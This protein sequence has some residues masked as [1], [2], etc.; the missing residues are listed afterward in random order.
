MPG[1]LLFIDMGDLIALAIVGV[2]IGITVL[3]VMARE[4]FRIW[5]LKRKFQA[6]Q[7]LIDPGS[8]IWPGPQIRGSFRGRELDG[9]RRN[10]LIGFTLRSGTYGKT[11][12]EFRCVSALHFTAF[13]LPL[14][15]AM[16]E[17]L[18]LGSPRVATG[19]LKVDKDFG[20][21][22]PDPD[23]LRSW[24]ENADNRTALLAF[25]S[26][27]PASRQQRFRVRVEGKLQLNM[28]EYQFF[29]MSPDRIRQLLE[30]LE[31]MAGK[32]EQVGG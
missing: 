7:A 15:P 28:P 23:R 18:H 9:Y 24:M 22:S 1:T 11:I 16:A 6:M 21:A 13:T 5:K 32:L 20:F 12:V 14:W 10:E 26:T 25:L 30:G 2:V 8:A 19:D 4:R 29:K 17:L 27:L 3:I 31:M